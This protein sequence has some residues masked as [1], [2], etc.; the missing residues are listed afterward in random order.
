MDFTFHIHV[1][2]I[3]LDGIPMANFIPSLATLESEARVNFCNTFHTVLH[4]Q[5]NLF[6][7]LEVYSANGTE[8]GVRRDHKIPT[9]LKNA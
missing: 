7:F 4:V 3:A 9:D 6:Y 5:E 2:E 8:Y 1:E